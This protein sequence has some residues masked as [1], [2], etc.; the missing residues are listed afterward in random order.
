MNSGQSVMLDGIKIEN[1]L[2]FKLSHIERTNDTSAFNADQEEYPFLFTENEPF[3][4]VFRNDDILQD[5]KSALNGKIVLQLRNSLQ[6]HII[7][8]I[9]IKQG[10]AIL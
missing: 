7:C 2:S 6:Q 9:F 3:I 5:I 1:L 4:F 10:E 8:T